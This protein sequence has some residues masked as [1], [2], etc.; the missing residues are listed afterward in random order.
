MNSEKSTHSSKNFGGVVKNYCSELVIYRPNWSRINNTNIKI[1]AEIVRK[2]MR[3]KGY[4]VS[5]N[6]DIQLRKDFQLVFTPGSS[7]KEIKSVI[8]NHDS[9]E[10]I[11]KRLARLNRPYLRVKPIESIKEK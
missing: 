9:N 4:K 2:D 6:S 5:I 1:N 3:M 7:R 10:D 11:L 8:K